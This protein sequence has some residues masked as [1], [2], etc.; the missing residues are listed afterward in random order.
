[1][2]PIQ[3][4]SVLL[5][6]SCLIG[7]PLYP[8]AEA[9]QFSEVR[10]HDPLEPVYVGELQ[11]RWMFPSDHLPIG[12]TLNN[13]CRIVTWNVLNSAY[14]SWI[15][16]NSQGFA[17]S[18]LTQEDVA[19]KENGFTLREHHV[20]DCLLEM[21]RSTEFPEHL[22]CLQECSEVFIQELRSRLPDPMNIIRSSDSPVKN[23]NIVLYDARMFG[24]VEKTLHA[25]VFA[26]EPGRPLMEVVLEKDG[27]PFRI[28]NAHLR[29]DRTQPQRF[30]LT[31][32]IHGR[33]KEGEVVIALGDINFSQAQMAEAFAA[34]SNSFHAFSP[35]KTTV[36]P[37]R[38]SKAIDH[39]FIDSGGH[40]LDIKALTPNEALQNLQISVDLLL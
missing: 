28:F 2:T 37:E 26:S 13:S 10:L 9:G 14:M 5:L 36:S 18:I 20:I 1:M 11:E 32:F 25:N 16:N 40:S 23:Q 17:R 19:I 7:D 31:A 3:I 39:I 30:E 35:Y 15:S 22:I 6:A 12:I 33:K 8:A 34:Q 29:C 21:V 38:N 24:F 27:I 4:I